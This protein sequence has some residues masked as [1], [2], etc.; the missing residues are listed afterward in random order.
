MMNAFGW[1]AD[2]YWASTSHEQWAVI[3][4][5]REAGEG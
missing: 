1:S 3:E 2:Q 5:R 4:A